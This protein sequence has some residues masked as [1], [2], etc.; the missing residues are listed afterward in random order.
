M[1]DEYLKDYPDLYNSLAGLSNIVTIGYNPDLVGSDT[2][3]GVQTWCPLFDNWHTEEQRQTYYDRMNTTDRL[4][5]EDA[6][7]YGCVGPRPPYPTYHLDDDLISPRILSWM[8]YD[9][10]CDGN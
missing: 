8:Q 10:R 4:M 3:G 2:E 9:Y 6:W 1:A 7:W 5:G